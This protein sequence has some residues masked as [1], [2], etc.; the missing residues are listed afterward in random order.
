MAQQHTRSSIQREPIAMPLPG[1]VQ[2]SCGIA[3]AALLTCSCGRSCRSF[4]AVPQQLASPAQWMETARTVLWSRLNGKTSPPI[5]TQRE[6]GTGAA[7]H[8][9]KLFSLYAMAHENDWG[10]VAQRRMNDKR[11]A[12]IETGMIESGAYI[13]P[14]ISQ[15]ASLT[16]D[17][18]R[19]GIC[20][21]LNS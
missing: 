21:F 8:A 6:E 9:Q 14:K 4:G 3:E 12:L 13:Y 20:L 18:N 2:S 11:E 5:T 15:Y 10:M 1:S 16:P 17:S 7:R 19:S